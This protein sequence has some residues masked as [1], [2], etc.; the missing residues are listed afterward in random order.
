MPLRHW[1][2]NEEDADWLSNE[3][4]LNEL[5]EFGYKCKTADAVSSDGGGQ[6]VHHPGSRECKLD[7]K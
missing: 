7:D 6:R 3:K 5:I 4:M 2:S 1:T